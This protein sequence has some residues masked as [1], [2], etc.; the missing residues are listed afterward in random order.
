MFVISYP[1]RAQPTSLHSSVI[2]HR[3]LE[4]RRNVEPMSQIFGMG[5]TV[6]IPVEDRHTGKRLWGA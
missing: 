3:I 2:V 4:G 6:V 1:S 5:I